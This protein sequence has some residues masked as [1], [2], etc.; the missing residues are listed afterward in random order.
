MA[1]DRGAI[2]AQ[3]R[4][5]GEGEHW[6]DRREFRALPQILQPEERIRGLVMGRVLPRR[7]PR[8]R[9]GPRGWLIVATEERLLCLKEE[10]YARKQIEIPRGQIRRILQG[11]RLRDFQV[12][13]DAGQR[14]YRIRIRKEDAFRFSGAIA[15]LFPQ[16]PD[17]TLPPEVEQWS[18]IPGMT[19]IAGLPGVANVVTRV[20]RLSPPPPAADTRQIDRLEAD[21]DRLQADVERLQQQVAFLEELLQKQSDQR[22]LERSSSAS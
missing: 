20:S 21:V 5:I 11:A 2:D 4:E 9:P 1:M 12:A 19:T 18:W 10:R 8:F 6:W 16:S 17:R 14:H 22:L 13:V 3:L 7:G 15:H